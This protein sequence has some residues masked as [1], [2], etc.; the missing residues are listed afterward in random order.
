M[1]VYSFDQIFQA[2]NLQV[3]YF[4]LCLLDQHSPISFVRNVKRELQ[5][6]RNSVLIFGVQKYTTWHK[7]STHAPL[8]IAHT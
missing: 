5:Q 7:S 6:N 3:T 1:P 8:L 4:L 2:C